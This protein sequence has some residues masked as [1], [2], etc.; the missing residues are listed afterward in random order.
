MIDAR[1]EG[2]REILLQ[3]GRMPDRVQQRLARKITELT[4][5]LLQ[6]VQAKE[7]VR[8][9]KL[10]GETIDRVTATQDLVRGVVTV[11]ADTSNEHAKAGALEYGAHGEV[12]V[13][14]FARHGHNPQGAPA[15]QIVEAYTRKADLIARRF[16]RNSLDDMSEEIRSELADALAGELR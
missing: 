16:E 3:L 14:E 13:H 6:R 5:R 2:E 1:V 11:A 15:D 8:T 4:H 12:T 9:G 7:P 10:R